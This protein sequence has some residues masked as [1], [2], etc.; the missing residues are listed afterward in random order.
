MNVRN[1]LN[2]PHFNN[3][4]NPIHHLKNFYVCKTQRG[5]HFPCEG[6]AQEGP[7]HYK[8][9]RLIMLQRAGC[10]PS[11]RLQTK[12]GNLKKADARGCDPVFSMS[13]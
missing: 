7:K 5:A 11:L 2:T 3:N 10:R 13:K 12:L 9:A 4:K 8:L 1:A 6:K